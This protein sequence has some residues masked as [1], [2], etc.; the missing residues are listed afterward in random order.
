M[1]CGIVSKMFCIVY[2]LNCDIISVFCDV[3]RMSVME[4][5]ILQQILDTQQAMAKGQELIFNELKDLKQG[6]TE[7]NQRLDKL[8]TNASETNQRLDKLETS[9]S[10]TNQR[11]NKLETNASETNQRLD[12]LETDVAEIKIQAIETKE[13]IIVMEYDNK[14]NFGAL[15]DGYVLLDRRTKDIQSSVDKLKDKQETHDLRII[16]LDSVTE[17]LD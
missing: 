13:R 15:Y 2:I 7:T 5:E 9:A 4:N 8:E 14:R 6:Q 16:R 11:L 12:K 17:K 3:E 1:Y 10:E